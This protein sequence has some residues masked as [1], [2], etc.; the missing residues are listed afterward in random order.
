MKKNIKTGLSVF[1]LLLLILF[2]LNFI[3][4]SEISN[5][6][7]IIMSAIIVIFYIHSL[8]LNMELQISKEITHLQKEEFYALLQHGLKTP[9]IAQIRAIELLLDGRL[10]KISMHQKEFFHIMLDSEKQLFDTINS[11]LPRYCTTAKDAT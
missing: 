9:A 3:L 8:K 11:Q 2:S 4:G 1:T 5:Y 10:G 6:Y 7:K